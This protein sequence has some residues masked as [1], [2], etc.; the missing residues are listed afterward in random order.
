[1]YLEHFGFRR[2]PFDIAPNS[3]FLYLS[4]A[5]KKAFTYL[6]YALWNKDTFT[7]LTGEIGAGKTILL[8]HLLKTMPDSAEVLTIYQTQMTPYELL[9]DIAEQLG[10]VAGEDV[11]KPKLFQ[12]L[13]ERIMQSD[14]NIVIVVDEAQSFS[15]E[16]LE[17]LRLLAGIDI[18]NAQTN[19][20][21]ILCGQ[22]ELKD[23]VEGGSLE[24]L[25]QRIKLRFHL[26]PLDLAE[27]REY[28]RFR[29]AKAGQ[30]LEIFTQDAVKRIHEISGGVPRLINVLADTALTCGYADG[31][32]AIS[33]RQV[34]EAKLELGWDR[35]PPLTRNRESRA[36][37]GKVVE[38]QRGNVQDGA[39]LN[40]DL[41]AAVIR[42]ESHLADIAE[43]L[44]QI[45]GS[46]SPE[47]KAK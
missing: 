15:R 35:H 40:K 44:R 34:E 26:T 30:Q 19:V 27:A 21:I 20:N 6:S 28:I 38:L 43:S 45:G 11:P 13:S 8:Q 25:N 33:S 47:R 39:G 14:K 2:E 31:F 37:G 3:D 7:L 5:H 10:L 12:L 29:V 24:Q 23:I 18:F 17:E 9:Y 1:M 16:T 46:Q 22:P 4:K 32:Y 36:T 42:I 41:A